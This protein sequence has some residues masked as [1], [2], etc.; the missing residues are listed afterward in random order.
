MNELSIFDYDYY[1]IH[2]MDVLKA[3]MDAFHHFIHYG[4]Q[5][6]RKYRSDINLLDVMDEYIQENADFSS[7]SFIQ[8][9]NERVRT[10]LDSKNNDSIARSALDGLISRN[11][12][13]ESSAATS[14]LGELSPSLNAYRFFASSN[15]KPRVN[16]VVPTLND[17]AVYGGIKTALDF[18]AWLIDE[19][20]DAVDFR[21]ISQNDASYGQIVG[22][23][24]EV[25]GFGAVTPESDASRII[26]S[27]EKRSETEFPIR[28]RE[29]FITTFWATSVCIQNGLDAIS[30]EAVLCHFLQDYEPNF[31][32]ANSL[33][34]MCEASLRH[35][36][37]MLFITNSQ[38]LSEF[39]SQT[40]DLPA[41][42]VPFTPRINPG[43]LPME[44]IERSNIVL[45]YARKNPRNLF[46]IARLALARL[47]E[48]YPG[49]ARDFQYIGIGDIEGSF[50]LA[51]SATLHCIGKLD[52]NE[53]R[54]WMGRAK[55]GF[56]LM[57]APHPSYPPLEM[58]YNGLRVVTNDYKTRK[59]VGI[60]PNIISASEPNPEQL[61]DLLHQQC[62]RSISEEPLVGHPF[63]SRMT[64]FES[65]SSPFDHL[66]ENVRFRELFGSFA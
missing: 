41:P 15:T 26:V 52:L 21:V 46:E 31:Y 27:G 50:K 10:M 29:V 32:P 56:S 55:V 37:N 17:A 64:G 58:A 2:N 49:V 43:L 19:M 16:I 11:N 20:S 9:V 59:M 35:E 38:H 25:H 36:R 65:S 39:V 18:F 24:S 5:E 23:L 53:Y 42:C 33:R 4:R 54:A 8:Y 13:T 57:M 34:Q 7:E 1:Y 45:V 40:C 66:R 28:N 61:C 47:H 30:S 12:N 51:N 60:H 14:I 63:G 6:G 44:D 22:R 48:K 3:R 62:A